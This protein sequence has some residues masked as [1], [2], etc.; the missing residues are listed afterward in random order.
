MSGTMRADEQIRRLA[1]YATPEHRCSYLADRTARTLFADPTVRLNADIYSRLSLYGFRR[2]GRHIYRPSCPACEACI[3]VR[4]PVQ[5]FRPRRSQRRVWQHN[6]DI[7]VVRR[8]PA[9][10]DEH[11]ALYRRYISMRHPGGGMDNPDPA[12]Y[13]DF[14]TAPWSE[15]AFNEFRADGR[16]LAVAVTDRLSHGLSA[17]YTFFDPALTRRGLGTYGIL[18]QIE[19]CRRL[20]L[21]WLYL[22]YWIAASAKMAYKT[23]FQPLEQFRDGRWTLLDPETAEVDDGRARR[24]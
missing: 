6:G 11:F 21:P 24:G 22:G 10:H 19:E 18:W 16:L 20:G 8:E 17:V 9:F 14:L 5:A 1:F 4:I 13:L 2:S 3:P 23:R 15:T 7:Q 12:Q